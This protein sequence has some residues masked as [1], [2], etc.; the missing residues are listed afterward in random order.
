M[1][2]HHDPVFRRRRVAVLA[3]VAA[4]LAFLAIGAALIGAAAASPGLV[5]GIGAGGLDTPITADPPAAGAEGDSGASGDGV[6]DVED[7]YIPEGEWISLHDD[8][9]AITK[10]DAALLDATRAAAA[11][12]AA[13]GIEFRVTSGWRSAE[14]QQQLLDDAVLEYGSLEEAR[15]FVSTPEGSNH[16]TGRAIDIGPTDADS[17]LSQ[18][19][20]DYGLCQTYANEMWH[21]EL[22]TEPGGECPQMLPDAS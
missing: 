15:R 22:S 2:T 21:F 7:G 17:W 13:D 9:P 10:L 1:R 11:D 8:V 20:S 18:H 3:A 6:V 14:Y 12:A 16:V 5:G 4:G 19:G